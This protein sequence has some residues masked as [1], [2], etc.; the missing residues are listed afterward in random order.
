MTNEQYGS[1]GCISY[2]SEP[3]EPR[4][5][6][7]WVEAYDYCESR[8]VHLPTEREWE[9]AARGPDG[10]IYPW[11]NDWNEDNVVWGGN[12]GRH[13]AT[14]GSKPDGVSWVGAYDLSGNV[15]EWVSTIYEAYPYDVEDGREDMD[16]ADVSHVLRGGSWLGDTKSLLR[17]SHR[18][19]DKPEISW[20]YNG[21][22]CARDFYEDDLLQ[23]SNDS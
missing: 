23:S 6:V 21:F 14:V 16:V 18:N 5:C 20:Y 4:N 22:R 9:Y 13:T 8:G 2:S 17:G 19:R 15:W 11:G 3:D 7:T 1:V 12:S 10:L